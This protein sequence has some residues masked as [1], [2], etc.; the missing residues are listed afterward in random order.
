MGSSAH[1]TAMR[2]RF[3]TVTALLL[4]ASLGVVCI[5]ADAPP[6]A[7]PAAQDWP[8][9]HGG[10]PLTGVAAPL[11]AGDGSGE[12]KLRWTYYT[13]ESDPAGIAGGA[14]IV[15]DTAYVGDD[16]GILHA[17]DLKT[18]K[19]KWA[20]K[21]ENGFE[22]TP[23]VMDGKVLIGDLAGVFHGVNAADGK[24]L[25]TADAGGASIHASANAAGPDRVVF[26][27]DSAEIFCL[28]VKDGKEVWR[29]AAG[30]RINATPAVANGLALVS[31]CD[32]K[33]RGISVADGTEKFA[34][35]MGALSGASPAVI[36]DRMYIGTDQGRVLCISAD[37]KTQHWLYEDV[38]GK[39]M[40]F[41][42][43]AV[44][45][46][47]VVV[48]ARDR[49]VHAIDAKTGKGLWRFKTRGDVESSPAISAGRV[50]VGSKDKKFYV[51][52]LKSGK[53]LWEF[54]A[55]RAVTAPPAIAN[56]VVVVGDTA[57]ALYC[58]E[59]K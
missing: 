20:H 38:E 48:G 53:K 26:G 49:H 27:T 24:P 41:A 31:G 44:D 51:L 42:S 34:Y 3:T 37:A 54:Q 12:L 4:I 21:T 16:A 5:A 47:I 35:D 36:G 30:D 7:A 1:D 52:D 18:G 10:G 2:H 58:F 29:K 43:A 57:G 23:L 46:D 56:G 13:D 39:A 22:T 11:P 50:Y 33:L 59:P 9:F 15:G 40:V 17:V 32:A 8:A 55:E 45:Q 28:S 14:A 6:A 25:W 19:R